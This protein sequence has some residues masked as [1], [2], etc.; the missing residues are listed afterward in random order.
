M[1]TRILRLPAVIERVGLSR[2]AIYARMAKG[3]F[4]RP[5]RIGARAVGWLEA[6]IDEWLATRPRGGSDRP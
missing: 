2:S 4:P 5:L 1:A 6:D 3:Q